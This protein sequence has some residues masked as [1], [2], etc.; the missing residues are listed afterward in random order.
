MPWLICNTLFILVSFLVRFGRSIK[1][2]E[3]RYLLTLGSN[4][5]CQK[6]LVG[7]LPRTLLIFVNPRFAKSVCPLIFL[8]FAWYG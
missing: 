8:I 6:I 7:L 2:A 5:L 3:L 4:A 1:S